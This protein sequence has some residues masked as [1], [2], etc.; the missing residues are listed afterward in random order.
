MSAFIAVKWLAIVFAILSWEINVIL[1]IEKINILGVPIIDHISKSELWMPLEA[2]VK[3]LLNIVLQHPDCFIYSKLGVNE[4]SFNNLN[5]EAMASLFE[6]VLGDVYKYKN[7]DLQ[8]G[9]LIE[10]A[11]KNSLETLL[12]L[13]DNECFTKERMF[14]VF[15]AY[16]THYFDAGN[17]MSSTRCKILT[18]S[19]E[20]LE[21]ANESSAFHVLTTSFFKSYYLANQSKE[22]KRNR[23]NFSKF[24]SHL[25]KEVAS[26]NNT[27][28]NNSITK[29]DGIV[30]GTPKQQNE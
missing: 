5:E 26:M 20:W 24:I 16:V 4:A 21:D 22:K 15:E 10:S 25:K 9:Y 6:S 23:H 27:L 28:T 13:K 30:D 17:Y 14:K 3:I 12:T 8:I 2:E 7:S 18:N 11:S 19:S 29:E 1:A